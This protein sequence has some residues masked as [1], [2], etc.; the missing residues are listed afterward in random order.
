MNTTPSGS[1]ISTDASGN[2]LPKVNQ[3]PVSAWGNR[4]LFTGREWLGELGLYDFRNRLYHPELGR[5]MQ[6]DPIQFAAGDYNLYRYCHNDPV[7]RVDPSGLTATMQGGG[8]WM[9][10]G[11][12]FTN[13]ELE[14][15]AK[16]FVAELNVLKASF[17]KQMNIGSPKVSWTAGFRNTLE[18]ASNFDPRTIAKTDLSV[19]PETVMGD[20]KVARFNNHLTINIRWNEDQKAWFGNGLNLNPGPFRAGEK[21]GEIM[22]AR[23][24]VY[25]WQSFDSERSASASDIGNKEAARMVGQSMTPEDA[26]SQMERAFD[27]WIHSWHD[28]SKAVLG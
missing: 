26:S 5:F 3:R 11:S 6:P 13:G 27:H 25:R 14:T 19:S 23:D 17:E 9:R 16:A 12:A 18:D 1:R 15:K 24:A 28:K 21:S 20:G 10:P 2:P 8:D 22:H 4:F 7:N